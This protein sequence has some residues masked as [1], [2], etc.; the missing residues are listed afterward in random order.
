MSRFA[1]VCLAL[2]LLLASGA[3]AAQEVGSPLRAS[4]PWS[5]L[6]AQQQEVL[7]PLARRW[8]DMDTASRE[9][10]LALA[11]K[12]PTLSNSEQARLRS[13][14]QEWANL[15][16]DARQQA[17]E[18]FQTAQRKSADERQAKWEA[19]QQLPADK[20][21][22]LQERGVQ[23]QAEAASHA[24]LKPVSPAVPVVAQ[25]QPGVSTVLL[26]RRQALV[27]SPW[28][29]PGV[30]PLRGSWALVDPVT[31]MPLPGTRAQRA[32]PGASAPEQP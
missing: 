31:L 6:T 5:T 17:R 18:G 1:P 21:Q 12:Y 9:K 19:Y 32:A 7:Q 25:V 10:W 20:R 14:V 16:S 30:A 26:S 8:P 22:A 23:R 15:S 29:S 4:K 13:R 2:A 24:R 11:A 3:A 27:P 28:L